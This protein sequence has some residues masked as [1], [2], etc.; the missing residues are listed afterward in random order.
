MAVSMVSDARGKTGYQWKEKQATLPNHIAK[1]FQR[2]KDD[3]SA[4]I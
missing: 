2:I 4:H 1:N 3:W